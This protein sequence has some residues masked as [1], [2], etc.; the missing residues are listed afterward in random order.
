MPCNCCM[1]QKSEHI[2]L[3]MSARCPNKLQ[4]YRHA[5]THTHIYNCSHAHVNSL[6][7]TLQL[8]AVIFWLF[9]TDTHSK[10]NTDT[11]IKWHIHR[12]IH[13]CFTLLFQPR[14]FALKICVYATLTHLFAHIYI[15]A[16]PHLPDSFVF[17]GICVNCY[18]N[19]FR[20]DLMKSVAQAKW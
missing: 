9:F 14:A 12:Y 18:N 10:E 3:T 11:N 17:I 19:V 20:S 6:L 16:L 5:C 8:A 4:P 13:T 7:C 1:Q 15:C 2:P